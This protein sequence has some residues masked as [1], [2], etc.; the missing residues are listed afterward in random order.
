MPFDWLWIRTCYATMNDKKKTHTFI[1][2]TINRIYLSDLWPRFRGLKPSSLWSL[3]LFHIYIKCKFS[4]N[5]IPNP[6]PHHRHHHHH[7]RSS[8]KKK[9]LCS[10][11]CLFILRHK[12]LY[13]HFGDSNIYLLMRVFFWCTYIVPYIYIYI[14]YTVY[15]Q[16]MAADWWPEKPPHR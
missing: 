15:P 13:T 3:S 14:V 9:D 16:D 8:T 7:H 1:I 10:M 4:I 2:H 12:S 5:A 11:F 6:I